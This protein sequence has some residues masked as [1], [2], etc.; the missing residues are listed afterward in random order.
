MTAQQHQQIRVFLKDLSI[1]EL[2]EVG[3]LVNNFKDAK[4][5]V[6]HVGDRVKVNHHRTLGSTFIVTKINRVKCK[7]KDEITG[8]QWGVPYSFCEKIK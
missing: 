5:P 1:E 6:L 8:E 4:S 2:R 7:V 3:K